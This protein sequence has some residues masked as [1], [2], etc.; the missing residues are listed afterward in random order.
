MKTAAAGGTLDG[1]MK[2]TTLDF[3]GCLALLRNTGPLRVPLLQV[4][5]VDS[6][7]LRV[8]D[9]YFTDQRTTVRQRPK[10]QYC[11]RDIVDS[12]VVGAFTEEERRSRP[13]HFDTFSWGGYGSDY[14]H[15]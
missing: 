3:R 9:W 4:V 12:F 8:E 6:R 1:T 15:S 2:Q 10:S 13:V 5:F 14:N 7:T 11:Y